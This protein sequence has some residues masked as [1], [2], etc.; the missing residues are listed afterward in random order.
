MP[1]DES[2]STVMF[3]GTCTTGGVVSCT[4]TLNE[5][6]LVLLPAA[7]VAVHVTLVVPTGN[8]VPGSCPPQAIVGATLL[9]SLALTV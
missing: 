1:D 8:V 5:G 9:L 4:V 6:V 3:D 2:A 7:S